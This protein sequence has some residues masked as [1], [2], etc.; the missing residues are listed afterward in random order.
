MLNTWLISQMPELLC[1][2]VTLFLS[3]GHIPYKFG[4]VFRWIRRGG[5]W[6][7]SY[8][9]TFSIVLRLASL[10]K[11]QNCFMGKVGLA[12]LWVFG[13]SPWALL[14]FFYT[15]FHFVCIWVKL[16]D[17]SNLGILGWLVR[18]Y[19]TGMSWTWFT[20]ICKYKLL[21]NSE[22]KWG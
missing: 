10:N 4:S 20:R 1:T 7:P 17:L 6:R 8:H 5:S 12:G 11:Q 19:S 13:L 3:A 9:L 15:F 18:S 16:P 14:Q 21:S 22:V 2:G